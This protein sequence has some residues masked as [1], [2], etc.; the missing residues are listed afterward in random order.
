MNSNPLTQTRDTKYNIALRIIAGAPLLIFGVMHLSGAAPMLPLVE[1]AELPAPALTAIA[2]P[3]VQILAG[4][5]LILG[6]LTRL[7]AVLGVIVMLG[8]LIT[9][10][11]IPNDQWPIPVDT[12]PNTEP[13]ILTPLAILVIILSAVLLFVGGGKW[14]VDRKVEGPSDQPGAANET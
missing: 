5:L 3:I 6:A 14:S 9:N 12:A 2:A 10:F 11:L 1:A 4:L 8:G 7:G 13:M